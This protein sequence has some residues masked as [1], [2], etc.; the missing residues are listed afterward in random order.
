MSG[1][2]ASPAEEW[3]CTNEELS[4]VES[5]ADAA[6]TNEELSSVE[7]DADAAGNSDGNTNFSYFIRQVHYIFVAYI[8]C[9]YLC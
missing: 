5:D 8:C 7:S 9:V 1:A 4:S 6:C 2:N 3:D